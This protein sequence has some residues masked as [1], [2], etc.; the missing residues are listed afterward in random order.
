M[1]EVPPIDPSVALQPTPKI[2][3]PPVPRVVIPLYEPDNT[4]ARPLCPQ[5][6]HC[7]L[8]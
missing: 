6:E 7:L 5:H 1:E 2:M 4:K 3:I 8:F